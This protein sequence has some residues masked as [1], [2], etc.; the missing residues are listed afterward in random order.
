MNQATVAPSATPP[1]QNTFV[2]LDAADESHTGTLAAGVDINAATEEDNNVDHREGTV[3]EDGDSQPLLDAIT[4]PI[5]DAFTAHDR[6]LTSTIARVDKA[7]RAL[8]SAIIGVSKTL[9]D[10]DDADTEELPPTVPH[11][12]SSISSRKTL[13]CTVAYREPLSI[14][15]QESVTCDEGAYKRRCKDLHGGSRDEC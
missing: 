7:D 11:G 13:A 5:I 8:D 3:R 10:D 14:G 9:D 4:D 2:L 6:V 15:G 12:N 1:L